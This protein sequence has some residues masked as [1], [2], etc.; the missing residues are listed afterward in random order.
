MNEKRRHPRRNTSLQCYIEKLQEDPDRIYSRVVNQ[1]HAGM[2]LVS[3]FQYVPGDVLKIVMD[4]EY[5]MVDIH[6]PVYRVGMVRWCIE[7]EGY[8]NRRYA[9]GVELAEKRQMSNE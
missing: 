7:Q 6:D 8:C 9:F 1:S 4:T 2:R 5:S 3:G